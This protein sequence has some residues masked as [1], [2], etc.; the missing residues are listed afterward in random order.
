MLALDVLPNGMAN[1]SR[2][3]AKPVK[4]LQR[5]VFVSIASITPITRVMIM[6][7]IIQNSEDVV[8]VVILSLSNHL[9]FVRVTV[10]SQTINYPMD[11]ESKCIPYYIP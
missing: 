7:F 5:V 3:V 1:M 9:D 11:F 2:I 6:S 10:D 4:S 8:I